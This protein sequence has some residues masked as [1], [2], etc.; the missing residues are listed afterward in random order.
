MSDRVEL[1]RASL[2]AALSPDSLTVEDQSH[3]HV[4]HAGAATGKGHFHVEIRAAAFNG[5]SK[6]Q[7]HRAIY[8]ALGELMETEIHALSI[9][10]SPTAG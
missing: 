7:Q 3:L 8:Q 1:I 9:D 4:G 5:Q 10:S 2:Q 6:I